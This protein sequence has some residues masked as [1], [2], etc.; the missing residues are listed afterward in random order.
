[1]KLVAI[2]SKKVKR[3]NSIKKRLIEPVGMYL[4]YSRLFKPISK[5]IKVQLNFKF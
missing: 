3:T 4:I 5:Y 2:Y 1:M